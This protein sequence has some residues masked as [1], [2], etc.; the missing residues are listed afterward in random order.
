MRSLL[1]LAALLI[2]STAH[3]H[4][5]PKSA[6]LLD[7]RSQHVEAD[8][9]LPVD[10]LQIALAHDGTGAPAPDPA[11]MTGAARA[12]IERYILDHLGANDGA[13]GHA[14]N[15]RMLGLDETDRD[16]VDTLI[17]HLSMDPP[18]GS[19]A[20]RFRL[21]YDVITRELVTHNV[22]LSVRTDWRNGVSSGA[23]ELV[24]PLTNRRTDITVD[25]SRGN[26]WGGF[27][28]IFGLGLDHIA[29]GTDHILFLLTLLLVAPVLAQ[30]GR[31]SGTGTPGRSIRRI[32]AIVTAF[33]VGHSL[34]LLLGAL[35]IVR[36][37]EPPIEVLIA[38]SILISSIHALRPIFPGREW[39]VAG[40]FGLIHGLA[41][42][43]VIG[44]L[45]LDRWALAA[46]ILGFNLGIET[47]QLLIVLATLPWLLILSTTHVY[48]VVRIAGATL[49]AVSAIGW[50]ADRALGLPNPIDPALD[51]LTA[52]A[53]WLLA[54]MA[55]FAIVVKA[56]DLLLV[57]RPP[58]RSDAE[59][60][61]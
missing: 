60:A 25:R 1:L 42:A 39:G 19:P 16:G 31:W 6:V 52:H 5:M 41:F 12:R 40:F 35:E 11:E 15:M 61:P 2:A 21:H 28:R 45:G 32:A 46:G 56:I 47:M 22:L 44:E 43:T 8:L 3:T 7:F 18:A 49:A 33:T 14:W 36:I 23:P 51:V 37:P 53:S 29:E 24:G 57:G 54:G 38:V 4:E 9:N 17:A 58:L 30:N 55:V 20:D 50:V 34:T 27:K 48:K 13:G 26:A 10:R 59:L